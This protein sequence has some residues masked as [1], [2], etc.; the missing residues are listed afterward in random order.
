MSDG[1]MLSFDERLRRHDELIPQPKVAKMLGVT[2]QTVRHMVLRGELTPVGKDGRSPLYLKEE[3]ERLA[4]LRSCRPWTVE[5]LRK[6]AKMRIARKP[7]SKI[8]KKL[9]RTEYACRCKFYEFT[10]KDLQDYNKGITHK[11]DLI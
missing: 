4:G 2:S 6:L 1:V 10:I 11:E 8:A 7:Y 5:E 9:G 3:V